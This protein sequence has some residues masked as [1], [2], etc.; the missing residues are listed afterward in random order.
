MFFSARFEFGAA[1]FIAW[2]GSLLDVLGGAMLAASCPRKKQ[3]SK[4]PS[5]GSS[6]SAAQSSTKEYVWEPSLGLGPRSSFYCSAP[7]RNKTEG[8][9]A[10]TVG[11]I[12]RCKR[13]RNGTLTL[14]LLHCWGDWPPN[15]RAPISLISQMMSH[16]QC[17]HSTVVYK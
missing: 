3:V 12:E 11:N 4:Y 2:G 8:L 14:C 1:I 10:V 6:R 15:Y 17:T 16:T 9:W 13:H 7:A 5:T